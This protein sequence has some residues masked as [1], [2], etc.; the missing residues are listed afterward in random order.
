MA[1]ISFEGK[2]IEKL[3]EQFANDPVRVMVKTRDT[4]KNVEQ[5]VVR[6]AAYWVH[7]VC[8]EGQFVIYNLN[9]C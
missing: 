4:S 8:L 6:V 1:L 3:I 2:P 9:L 5:D 7:K